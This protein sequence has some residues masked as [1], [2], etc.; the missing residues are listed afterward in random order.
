MDP[1]KKFFLFKQSKHFCSVPWNHIEI[2]TDGSV[3]TCAK[4]LEFGNLIDDDIDS[5]LNSPKIKN[6]KQSLVND[7]AHDNCLACYNLSTNLEHTDLRNHY[8]PMFKSVEVDYEN[9]NEFELNGI[10]LHW[11]NTCNLKCIYCHAK[12]S[13]SIASE[14]KIFFPKPKEQHL[15]QVVD[16]ILK[17]QWHLKEIYMS[18]GEPMLIK[19]NYEL[20]KRLE[21]VDIPLRINSNITQVKDNNIFYN[22]IKRFKNVL[23]TISAEASDDRFN[24]IRYGSDWNEFKKSVDKIKNLGHNIRLNSVW[25][26]GSMASLFDNIRFF[27]S[28]YDVRDFTINQLA[29]HPYFLVRNAPESLKDKARSD[30]ESLLSSEYV[31]QGSNSYYNIA[32]CVRELDLPIEDAS[33]YK[34]Y[35]DGLDKIRGTNWRNVFREL[36]Q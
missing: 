23:W 7:Q 1:K 8:N 16:L 9:L 22:E 21:N 12:Q 32:R 30:I 19:H 6:I 25:F 36:D 34:D 5:I 31:A 14:Q 35:L 10:D 27:A 13:S 15:E 28:Q 29:F 20:L 17:N 24:Y 3:K 2:F 18:G 26:L 33:G 11:D 4:G